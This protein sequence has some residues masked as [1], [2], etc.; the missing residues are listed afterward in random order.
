LQKSSLSDEPRRQIRQWIRF[1]L[2]LVLAT[3]SLTAVLVS[4]WKPPL[5]PDSSIVAEPNLGN[6]SGELQSE[7]GNVSVSSSAT[8]AVAV[9]STERLPVDAALAELTA[10]IDSSSVQ[11]T[12]F[13]AEATPDDRAD[14]IHLAKTV[15]PVGVL[16][17]QYQVEKTPS[18]RAGLLLAISEYDA[19]EVMAAAGNLFGG[20]SEFLDGLY[21]SYV[22]DPDAELHSCLE[23][24]LRQWGHGEMLE[25]LRPL[26]EQRLIPF[27]G[28]WFRPFHISTMVVVPGPR[29]EL[30]GLNTM[31]HS[32][33][34]GE[35]ASPAREVTIPYS[36]AIATTEVTRYQFWRLSQNFWESLP[37]D[38]P[39]LPVNKIR[40]HQA[41]EF[42]NR[43][44][45]LDGMP[46]SQQC[47]VLADTASGKLWRQ[48]P[49]ALELSGYRLPT[50]DEWEIACRA[51]SKTLRHFG[52]TPDWMSEYLA[53][54]EEPS[55]SVLVGT[56]KPNAFGL[57]DM[58]GNVSE[59]IHTSPGEEDSLVGL[60]RLRGGSAWTS[61]D[62]LVSHARFRGDSGQM[63]TKVG[64]RVARTLVK[65]LQDD[66]KLDNDMGRLELLVGPPACTEELRKYVDPQFQ[67]VKWKQ[68]IRLG[69]WNVWSPVKRMM[70]L[71]NVSADD[72]TFVDDLDLKGFFKFE[73]TP[74]RTIKGF[75]SAD[76]GVRLRPLAATGERSQVLHFWWGKG[77]IYDFE[78]FTLHG[79]FE[80]PLVDLFEIGSFDE[81]SKMIDLGIVPVN[82]KAGRT[83]YIRNVGGIPV[84][85]EVTDV[86]G[87]FAL[88][89]PFRETLR[90]HRLDYRFR[91]LI[92]PSAVGPISGEVTLRT[93]EDS[94][95]SF[96]FPV[97]ATVISDDQFSSLAIFRK[98]TWLIDHNCDA[99]A[100]ETIAFG[101]DGDL[102][103]TGDW[104]GDG[105][106]DLA[107]WRRGSDGVTTVKFHLR[108]HLTD[109]VTL[110]PLMTIADP[111]KDVV[112]A[113]RD[114][115]GVCEVGYVVAAP[116]GIDLNWAFDT[117]HDGTFTE[118][119]AFGRANDD[120]ITGDWNG[121]GLDDIAVSRPGEKQADGRR[122]FQ[123]LRNGL[124]SPTE[125][126]H[127]SP[128]DKPIA[129]D[130]D[131]DGDDDPGSW[132]PQ[133]DHP[134]TWQFETNGDSVSNYD[135]MG[136]GTNPND[137][138]PVVLRNRTRK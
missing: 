67:P 76:F 21:Y 81:P 40:W 43:L 74:E 8:G 133:R 2:L 138:K 77:R 64:F 131:A 11:W 89:S 53:R 31:D 100:D 4:F 55:Q 70:R 23:F 134:S 108:G 44:T 95:R 22:N 126:V 25:R 78:P 26:L 105:I 97:R 117:N 38:N 1:G 92:A 50:D 110:K 17:K 101:E 34:T 6:V 135:L 104:D 125:L 20:T 103:L 94:P 91:L 33:G 127:F 111:V 18:L 107:V 36:F 109:G 62:R 39:D 124:D 51:G 88:E 118:R 87:P 114:G 56:R 42:C 37:P 72:V 46:T 79:C 86:K 73:P 58:L 52:D 119:F 12:I 80:G 102:P 121:D 63:S 41:V 45:E 54:L 27:E 49:N 65:T 69:N 116:N 112:A 136:F 96:T 14:A 15:V 83:F 137:D 129:G 93:I 66:P 84:Q 71:R 28:G 130:W 19:T 82:S 99:V 47:Y 3:S 29:T 68:V 9:S 48:K 85:V 122:L 132:R 115:D 59:W 120:V 24:L 123:F 7:T 90:P 30:L 13:G 128:Y 61:A 106:C 75:A 5:A 60:K 10:T 16:L 113:D 98:G 57:F 35:G 32:D